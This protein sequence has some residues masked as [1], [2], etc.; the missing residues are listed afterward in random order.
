[1]SQYR[2]LFELG[3]ANRVPGFNALTAQHQ[4]TD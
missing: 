4:A 2:W 3:A 1:M